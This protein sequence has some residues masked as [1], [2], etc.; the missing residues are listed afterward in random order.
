MMQQQ[1]WDLFSQLSCA[2]ELCQENFA[3]FHQVKAE[4][5]VW[6]V[7]V[8]AGAILRTLELIA[9]DEDEFVR[10]LE[11]GHLPPSNLNPTRFEESFVLEGK[12]LLPRL[13][14]SFNPKKT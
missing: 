3:S 9:A 12:G 14:I 8:T 5:P 13:C 2:I 10:Y 4:K 6:Y 7:S 11:K 1:G